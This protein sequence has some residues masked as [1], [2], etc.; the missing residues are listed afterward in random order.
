MVRKWVISPTYKW[1]ILGLQPTRIIPFLGSVD[2][3][4]DTVLPIDLHLPVPH[5]FGRGRVSLPDILVT[6]S[7]RFQIYRELE[8]QGLIHFPPLIYKGVR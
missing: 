3:R 8:D 2:L 1:S 7:Q 6:G 5:I 4:G